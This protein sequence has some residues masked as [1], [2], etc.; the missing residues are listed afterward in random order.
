MRSSLLV[1]GALLAVGC[2]EQ[3]TAFYANLQ[4]PRFTR[5]GLRPDGQFLRSSNVLALPNEFPPGSPVKVT[6]YSNIKVHMTIHGAR[7][8]MIPAA[9]GTFSTD[10]TSIH[11]FLDKYFV[12]QKSD[13]LL[14]NEDTQKTIRKGG[15]A[16]GM[17][18]QQVFMSLGPPVFVD[19]DIPALNLS[20]DA[21]FAKDRWTYHE[22]LVMMFPTAVEFIFHDNLLQEAI[23]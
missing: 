8:E 2:V 3:Q 1:F 7:Y 15:Y 13:L 17:T 23:R 20:R 19:Q 16:V 9:D 12:N 14:G 5:V 18:K 22:S 10:E 11:Y 21:I 4:A 6:L